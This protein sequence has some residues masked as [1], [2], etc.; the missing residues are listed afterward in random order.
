M[1]RKVPVPTEL[2]R[3]LARSDVDEL[4][5]D[6]AAYIST[7][8]CY[9]K[10]SDDN[11]ETA[12]RN[13]AALDRI[14]DSGYNDPDRLLAYIALLAAQPDAL[15]GHDAM[16]MGQLDSFFIR[17][18][19]GDINGAAFDPIFDRLVA[20]ARADDLWSSMLRTSAWWSLPNRYRD[21]LIK[22]LGFPPDV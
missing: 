13:D 12:D 14:A 1:S 4:Q 7:G 16:A 2:Q 20:A 15:E 3:A 19:T 10:P 17:F 5:A 22:T 6:I 21:Q 18:K 11:E 8:G 9:A